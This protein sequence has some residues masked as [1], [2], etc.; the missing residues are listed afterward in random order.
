MD[1]SIAPILY[2][3]LPSKV[4]QAHRIKTADQPRSQHGDFV[5][6]H[7]LARKIYK[8]IVQF[9]QAIAGQ[10]RIFFG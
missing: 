5:H 6:I 9:L 2:L 4:L 7:L 8:I 3:I 1:R 10:D